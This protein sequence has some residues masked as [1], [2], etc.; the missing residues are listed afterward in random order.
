MKKLICSAAAMCL[1]MS[2]SLAIADNTPDDD[3]SDSATSSATVDT[4][5]GIG[6]VKAGVSLGASTSMKLG[7]D[8]T[9]FFN[10]AAI[11]GMTEVEAAN[12]ARGKA[13][14]A[15]TKSFADMM[16]SDHGKN[17]A[18]LRTLA[19]AKGVSL[20][21]EMDR[22][23]RDLIEDLQ[24]KKSGKDFDDKYVDEME[25]EHEDA[26]KL[27]EKA[28]KSRDADVAAFAQKTLPTLRTHL[29][30]VRKLDKTK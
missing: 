14:D 15:D 10:K 9:D 29:E 30:M 2:T 17:N 24:E 11:A 16:A 19:S 20:P 5:V 22:H 18:E 3:S 12:I 7:K 6:G 27:F 23:H 4:T 26:V 13:V 21:T 8:E 28:A 1:A 25:D